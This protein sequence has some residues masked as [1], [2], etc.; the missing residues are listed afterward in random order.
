MREKVGRAEQK[1]ERKRMNEI[2]VEW[3]RNINKIR[4][5]CYHE[6]NRFSPQSK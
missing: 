3:M 1:E 4:L 5:N 2:Q 6:F